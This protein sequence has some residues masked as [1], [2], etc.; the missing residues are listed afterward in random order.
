MDSIRIFYV[1]RQANPSTERIVEFFTES[2][3]LTCDCEHYTFT[4]IICRHIFRVATQLNLD[5]LPKYLFLTRW[6]KDPENTIL[7]QRFRE[8]YNI[9]NNVVSIKDGCITI[10]EDYQYLLKRTLDRLQRFIKGR[11]E[12]AKFFYEIISVQ[13]GEKMSFD[14]SQSKNNVVSSEN[15]IK[16]PRNIKPKGRPQKNRILSALEVSNKPSKR[17]S[18]NKQTAKVIGI[19]L[20]VY[21][22]IYQ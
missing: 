7:V 3:R 20:I 6:C 1:Q 13:L 22:R 12:D 11:P 15:V 2:Q 4:G 21:Q 9:S 10:E 16:N 5:E 14:N 17:V 18:N 8:F 19:C